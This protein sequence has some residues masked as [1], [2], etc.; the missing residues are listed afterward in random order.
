MNFTKRFTF[1]LVHTVW[2][3]ERHVLVKDASVRP[4][5]QFPIAWEYAKETVFLPMRETCWLPLPCAQKTPRESTLVIFIWGKHQV[6]KMKLEL[7]HVLLDRYTPQKK[8]WHLKNDGWKIAFLSGIAYFQGRP[9]KLLNFQGVENSTENIT[10]S[11]SPRNHP[12]PQIRQQKTP[13]P[14]PRTKPTWNCCWGANLGVW[15]A[16]LLVEG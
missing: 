3:V 13:E 12:S 15:C 1:F 6:F 9:V 10:F 8:T 5:V 14:Q 16:I 11:H 4:L 2:I 7:I